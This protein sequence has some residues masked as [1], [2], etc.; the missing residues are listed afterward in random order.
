MMIRRYIDLV[1]HPERYHGH[2]SKRPFFEG[3]YYKMIDASEGSRFA[4]IPGIFRGTQPENDHAFVQILDG[5]SGKA[6]YHLYPANAFKASESDFDVWVGRNHF[7]AHNLVLDI[8]D[9]ERQVK[10]D[11]HFDGITPWPVTWISPGIMGWFGWLAFMECYHG[12]VSLD[13]A[14]RGSV[15]IDNQLVDFAG[16]RGYIE[17]D[18]GQAFPSAYIWMQTNHFHQ[19]GNCLTASVAMIPWRGRSFRGAI[20]GLWHDKTLYRFANYT[21]AVTEKLEITDD[22][23]DWIARDSK[24]RL[25]MRAARTEGS[26][27][28]A[29]VRTE[30]H[31]RVNETMQSS[32]E[33]CLSVLTDKRVIFQGTG[34]NAGLEVYGDLETLLKS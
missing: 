27:L 1:M 19:P 9:T 21:S 8:D 2:H 10:G 26:L 5:M 3:W 7:T 28:H 11:V 25:E 24:H 15:T 14:L 4:V 34:R 32:V 12:V 17:K 13:H 23:V 20:I 6:T 16:G 30:M 18:W 31:K 29:P 33:V 22:H